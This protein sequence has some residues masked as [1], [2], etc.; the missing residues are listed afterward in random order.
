MKLYLLLGMMTM[1]TMMS[2]SKGTDDVTEETPT[3]PETPPAEEETLSFSKQQG[4]F[5]GVTLPYQQA[6]IRAS[7]GG[8]AAL[9]LYLHGGSSKGTDNEK[10]M[11]EPG[12]ESVSG[13]LFDKKIHATMLV[14]QCPADKQWDM[15]SAN[16]KALLDKFVNEG[17]VDTK[18]IY[19][20]G[21]S[22]GGTGTWTLAN[23]YPGFFAAVMPVAGNPSKCTATNFSATPVYTVMG[24]ADRLM[25]VETAQTFIA[26]IDAAGGKTKFDTEEGWSHEDTCTKSYTDTRLEWVFS[27]TR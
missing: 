1:A 17:N 14:P 2:C 7:A 10:Q 27:Q 3:Q 8:K 21:G 22:M 18:R 6:E 16:L 13:Y 23:A 20:F 12:I 15:L 11:A 9:V 4:V 19:V 24:T 5:G 25:S 26:A